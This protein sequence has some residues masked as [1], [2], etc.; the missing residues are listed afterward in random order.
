MKD[1][2]LASA[3]GLTNPWIDHFFVGPLQMR[4][5]VV[6]DRSTGDTIIIDGGDEPER[7]IAWVDRHEGR[8]PDWST[9]PKSIDADE[10]SKIPK[11]RVVALVNTHAH[12]DHSGFIP[13]LKAHYGVDWYLHADDNFLQTLAQTSALRYGMTLPEPAKADMAFEGG[14]TYHFGSIQL[15]ILHTPGHTLG[16][17]CLLVRCEGGPDHVFVGDTLFAGSVGRTDIAHSGGDFELLA[18]SIHQQLWPLDLETVV[19]PGHGPLTTIGQERK[20]NPFVGDDAGSGIYGF[21]K[22]A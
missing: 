11:R 17:C 2:L 4:C 21:G 6:T 22:Y 13:T 7:I 18:S 12:F 19:H 20:T 16:G 8:G 3:M 10:G 14:K 15:E 5:S 1:A 9:G